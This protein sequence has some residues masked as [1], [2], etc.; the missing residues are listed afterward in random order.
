MQDI[1]SF[2]MP[3]FLVLMLA[4]PAAVPASESCSMLGGTCRDVCGGNE[5][6]EGGD[7]EDCGAKQECCI[8]FVEAPVRCCVAS[9]DVK[10]FGLANCSAPVNGSCPQGSASPVPCAK[11]RMCATPQ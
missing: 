7:F 11:L 1:R 3:C 2:I 9:L 5:K 6:A 10:N 4:V 8:V